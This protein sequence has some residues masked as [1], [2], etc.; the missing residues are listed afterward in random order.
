MAIVSDPGDQAVGRE[1]SFQEREQTMH[2]AE[3]EDF[4]G[5]SE[6]DGDDDENNLFKEEDG[7]EG[8]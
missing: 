7:L 1:Y 2:T 8:A 3:G 5:P 6:E 4:G